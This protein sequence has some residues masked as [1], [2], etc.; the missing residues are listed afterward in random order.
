VIGLLA[1]AAAATEHAPPAHRGL[2]IGY[3]LGPVVMVVGL[4]AAAAGSMWRSRPLV[5]AAT[6]AVLAGA[7]SVT[8]PFN[9]LA[10]WL[11]LL[12]LAGAV[13]YEIGAALAT[14]RVLCPPGNASEMERLRLLH[15]HTHISC[16]AGEGAK[17]GLQVGGGVIGYQVRWGVA[18]AVGDPLTAPGF[19]KMA[20]TAFLSLCDGKRWVPCFFQTDPGLR[21]AYRDAG[22]RLLKFGEEAV[23]EIRE[24]ELASPARADARHELARAR[25]SGLEAACFCDPQ[26]PGE[27]WAELEEVSRDWLR[28]R[29][30]REMGFSLGRL[31]DVVDSSTRYTVARDQSGRVHAF[32]SWVRMGDDGIALD[33]IRR[34]PDA[35]AGA[36]DLC[37]TT[38][39]ERARSEGLARVSLGSVPFRE[40]LGDAPDGR[41]A[42][43]VRAQ[44]YQRGYR[45]YSYRGLSHFKA[46]FAT[47][48]ESRDL[49]VPRGV[50][51]LL[52]LAALIRLHSRTEPATP[53]P[54]PVPLGLTPAPLP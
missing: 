27:L 12:A 48:W 29:G 33:L 23:V 52:A 8:V 21:P 2:M 18:V 51:G 17:S 14:R 42:R 49:A 53:A 7:F 11:G 3:A 5:A 15:G 31:R 25:R 44:L 22:F 24:F 10:D 28:V 34:R 16:F 19:R 26:A 45:G 50:R 6:F 46:K 47:R 41:L 32:C 36:V 30:G 40:S 1:A 37:I 38:A 4:L 20:V 43:R 9:P 13:G 35:A 54:P 39:I